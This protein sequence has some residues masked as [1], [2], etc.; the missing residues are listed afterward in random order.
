MKQVAPEGTTLYLSGLGVMTEKFTASGGA[1]Q[2]NEYLTVAGHAVGGGLASVAVG[3]M[4]ANGA[5]NPTPLRLLATPSVF[6][7]KNNTGPYFFLP[8]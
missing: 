7:R 8:S 4:F 6:D 5:I 2:G 3:G 1:A